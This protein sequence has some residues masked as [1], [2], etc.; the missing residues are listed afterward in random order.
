MFTFLAKLITS[1]D[2]SD[3][4]KNRKETGISKPSI[5]SAL[6]EQFTFPVLRY[7]SLD[8][9]HLLFINLGELLIPLWREQ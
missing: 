1:T 5:F 4:E 7:F 9:M 2:Q 6:V 3:Y 8:L